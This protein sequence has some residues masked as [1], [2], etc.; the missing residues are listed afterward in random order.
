M[1][2]DKANITNANSLRTV[3]LREVAIRLWNPEWASSTV[4]LEVLCVD[5]LDWCRV[6]LSNLPKAN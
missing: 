1:H 2:C 4:H 6:L 3:G 5:N